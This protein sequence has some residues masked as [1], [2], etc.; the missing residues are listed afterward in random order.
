MEIAWIADV[1]RG[2]I[3]SVIQFVK[4]TRR[5][6]QQNEPRARIFD[7]RHDVN[8]RQLHAPHCVEANRGIFHRRTR[9]KH[10]VHNRAFFSKLFGE[11]SLSYIDWRRLHFNPLEN[12]ITW[13]NSQFVRRC[14]QSY[15]IKS[16]QTHW[17]NWQKGFV[18]SFSSSRAQ[19]QASR[20]ESVSSAVFVL[21]F[22]AI[23]PLHR[24]ETINSG[25]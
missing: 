6:R 4:T 2:R 15:S 13:G 16:R 7:A 1:Y 9:Q 8:L 14:T 5:W 17:N 19:P 22:H 10:I 24:P 20:K 25:L 3:D 11:Y 12:L 18:R 21:S 23:I